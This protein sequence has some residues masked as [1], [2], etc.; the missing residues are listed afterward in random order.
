MNPFPIPFIDAVHVSDAVRVAGLRR[1]ALRHREH[2]S[3]S[4]LQPQSR[5]LMTATD[6]VVMVDDESGSGVLIESAG[7][8]PKVPVTPCSS[9]GP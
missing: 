8:K 5:D 3:R 7:D 4:T 1:G 9:C 2:S 6:G